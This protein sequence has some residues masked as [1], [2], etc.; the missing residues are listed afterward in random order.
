MLQLKSIQTAF[1]HLVKR[2]IYAGLAAL[3]LSLGSGA[4]LLAF[5]VRTATL[6]RNLPFPQSERLVWIGEVAPSEPETGTSFPAIDRWRRSSSLASVAGFTSRSMRLTH[7]AE[8]GE[9]R[10]ALTTGDFFTTFGIR[11]LLGRTLLENDD[12]MDGGA[13]IVISQSLWRKRFASDSAVVDSTIVVDGVARRVVG[14]MPGSFAFPDDDTDAWLPA[15]QSL[16][17]FANT[18]RVHLLLAIGRLRG[19]ATAARAAA[20]LRRIESAVEPHPLP[21]YVPFVRPLREQLTHEIVPRVRVLTLAGVLMLMLALANFA[22]LFIGQQLARRRDMA[23]R[24]ALGAQPAHLIVSVATEV[25]ALVAV[26]L[27]IGLVICSGVLKLA[28]QISAY[29]VPE[30]AHPVLGWRAAIIAGGLIVLGGGLLV[31]H[32]WITISKTA[33]LNALGEAS[34]FTS[35]RGGRLREGLVIAQIAITLTL[36]CGS[37]VLLKS[38]YR[39]AEAHHGLRVSDVFTATLSRPYTVLTPRERPA[40][41]AFMDGFLR[42]VAS[43]P[44]IINVAISTEAPAGRN[45]VQSEIQTRDLTTSVRAGVIAVSRDYFA[46]LG[47]PLLAGRLPDSWYG[48]DLDGRGVGV[49]DSKLARRLFGGGSAVGRR[50]TLRDLDQDIEITGIVGDVQQAGVIAEALPLAYLPYDAFPLPWVTV[51]VRSKVGADPTLRALREAA[52]AMDPQQSVE[53]FAALAEV[54]RDRLDRS[55]FYS[56]TLGSFAAVSLLLTIIGLYGVTALIAAER[57]REFGVRLSLGATPDRIFILVST[58]ALAAS[59]LGVAI[60]G[61]LTLF[62]T[63]A[64]TALLYGI[65]PLDPFVF[66][67]AALGVAFITIAAAWI[68][69]RRAAHLDPATIMRLG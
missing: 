9:L 67:M 33:P 68:P 12:R 32:A 61:I 43:T 1:F 55:A 4:C 7:G 17:A 39:L 30:L 35:R 29:E 16:S 66:M 2:P 41:R 60:G 65:N 54:L 42:N 15:L 52:V 38:F 69:A 19:D 27:A 63:R 6:D 22:N 13:V 10:V 20:E 49:V 58:R 64:L 48:A 11:A 36:L 5:A 50:V 26:G 31:F 45:R 59:A 44:G 18:E 56:F 34:G 62:G 14:V 53:H 46:V 3:A 28:G 57:R 24:R 51:S 47:I 21:S 25:F 23:V 8:S 37:G 40:V